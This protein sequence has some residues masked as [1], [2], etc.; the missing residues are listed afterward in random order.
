MVP[1]SPVKSI[2]T[3]V[4]AWKCLRDRACLPLAVVAFSIGLTGCSRDEGP[5]RGP[6]DEVGFE[7]KAQSF[8][9]ELKSNLVGRELI[10]YGGRRFRIDFKEPAKQSSVPGAEA[11]E[12]YRGAIVIDHWQVQPDAAMKYRLACNLRCRQGRWE[13]ESSTL[14]YLGL[15]EGEGFRAAAGYRQM[16]VLTNLSRYN[17]YRRPVEEAFGK[18][19]GE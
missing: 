15:D 12:D 4:I 7:G 13:L 9:Q 6:G 8:V 17:V 18:V 1:N 2:A 11:G 10:G 16:P 3:S 14:R 5:G 19:F